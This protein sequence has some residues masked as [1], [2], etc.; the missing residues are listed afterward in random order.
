MFRKGR[1]KL[2]NVAMSVNRFKQFLQKNQIGIEVI[3]SNESTRTAQEAADVH[4]VP[5][6]NIVKSLL[7]KA[8]EDFYIFLVPGDKRLDMDEVK[9]R[10]R[11]SSVRMASADEVKSITGYSIGGVP[12][13]GHEK[14][15]K[16]FVEEGF[17]KESAIVA[18]AGSANAVF[19]TRV[20]ELVEIL[21]DL[22][23]LGVD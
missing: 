15:L 16:V 21:K 20:G 2:Y 10:F 12:P 9:K 3:E 17:V 11:V 19:K 18:A 23:L 5:V 4:G 14:D 22:C 1:A 7:V 6:S 13:F 8:G